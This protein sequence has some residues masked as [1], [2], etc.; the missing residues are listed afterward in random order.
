[1]GAAKMQLETNKIQVIKDMVTS[2]KGT[3]IEGISVLEDEGVRA[4]MINAVIAAS[5]RSKELRE[6][7][8]N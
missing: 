6:E 4:A 1:M 8:N 5:E 3:T 7:A 2:P